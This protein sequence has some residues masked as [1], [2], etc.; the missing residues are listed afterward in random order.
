MDTPLAKRNVSRLLPR[1]TGTTRLG[2]P[3][4]ESQETRKINEARQAIESLSLVLYQVDRWQLSFRSGTGWFV[5]AACENKSVRGSRP[6]NC[7]RQPIWSLSVVILMQ[8]NEVRQGFFGSLLKLKIPIP[9]SRFDSL[10]LSG[11]I[12]TGQKN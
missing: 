4:A 8:D 7:S 9:P 6:Q 5:A 2:L 1:F 10:D 3:V 11:A 12:R